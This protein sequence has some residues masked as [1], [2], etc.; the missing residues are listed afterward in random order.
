MSVTAI[1]SSVP[2]VT[3]AEVIH[4]RRD[5]IADAEQAERQAVE[6]PYYPEDGIVPE[7][8]LAYAKDCRQRAESPR[9]ELVRVLS[10][11]NLH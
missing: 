9:V 7:T 6:G 11:F 2:R 3:S 8:L 1:N 4:F 10:Q 5:L